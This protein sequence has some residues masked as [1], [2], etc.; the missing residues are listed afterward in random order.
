MDLLTTRVVLAALSETKGLLLNPKLHVEQDDS[1]WCCLENGLYEFG[2]CF[3]EQDMIRGSVE[4]VPYHDGISVNRCI[5]IQAY[6]KPFL[7]G[8]GY[9]NPEEIWMDVGLGPALDGS[10]TNESAIKEVQT[11]LK[12]AIQDAL[13]L[14]KDMRYGEKLERE[15]AQQRD[16]VSNDLY[17]WL[18]LETTG[19]DPKTGKILEVAV[20]LTDRE[21][22]EKV[23]RSFL[24]WPED[25]MHYRTTSSTSEDG[26]EH[27]VMSKQARWPA[28]RR[29]NLQY[30]DRD[31]FTMH[32][33]SGLVED[34]ENVQVAAK[35]LDEMMLVENEFVWP[36]PTWVEQYVLKLIE[37]TCQK[38][39]VILAGKSIHF[40]R[41]WIAAHMP[42]LHKRLHYRHFDVRTLQMAMNWRPAFIPATRTKAKHRAMADVRFSLE[43]ARRYREMIQDVERKPAF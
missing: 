32:L 23:S 40:D 2:I 41:S 17:L 35:S 21:L 30:F 33:R 42:D 29:L 19:L 18:D 26:T 1:I 31:A 10:T 22:R 15:I 24:I 11:L 43:Y 28:K 5:K 34:L 3:T 9:E 12:I 20:V 13:A 7:D 27:R 4:N 38:Q 25:V 8:Y 6:W 37:E 16:A 36:N 14:E 39:N